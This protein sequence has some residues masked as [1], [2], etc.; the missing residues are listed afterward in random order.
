MM[1]VRWGVV[2]VGRAGRARVEAL[3]ADPRSTVVGGWR[4]S[5][6]SIGIRAFQ[7]FDELLQ[8]VD[9]VAI[10][11]PDPFHATQVHAALSAYRHVVCEFPLAGSSGEASSLFALSV[12]RDRV[13]HV[14]HIELLTPAAAWVRDFCMG[15]TLAGGTIRFSGGPR[16]RVISPAHANIARFHRIIDSAG[17]PEDVAVQRCTPNHLA[18]RLQFDNDVS[19]GLDCRME[20]GLK[21]H[22][23]MVLEFEEGIVRQE[24][25]DIFL[26]GSKVELEPSSGLFKADQLSATAA[27][28]DGVESYVSM[29]RVLEG[30]SLADLVMGAA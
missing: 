8:H 12:A 25:G 15:K 9:A 17:I 5:P 30:L 10:C 20:E 28:L 1:S 14:E 16:D 18:V 23:E 3:H 4:G 24:G 11:S 19:L 6:E 22:L 26:D 27:I 29:E 13:L 7:S 2:G 21:R